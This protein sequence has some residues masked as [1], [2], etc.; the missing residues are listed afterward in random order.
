MRQARMLSRALAV[1]AAAIWGMAASGGLA[2]PV[3]LTIVHFN[4]L[5]RMEEKGG[6]GGIARLAA[7]IAGR[8]QARREPS[9]HLCRR[10]DLAIAAVGFRQGRAHDRPAEQ[11]RSL[12]D[13]ARQPRIRFGPEVARRRIAEAAFPVLGANNRDADGEIID[14]RAGIDHRRRRSVHGRHLRTDHDPDG[15]SIQAPEASSFAPSSRSPRNRRG[16][17]AMPVPISS[18]P[19]LIPTPG[20]TPN[21]SRKAPSM[22]C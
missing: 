20:R 18:L 9:G 12:R 14:G 6:R 8:T 11:A 7:V 19:S 17:C 5:D 15:R 16:R 22:S 21:Y 13:G 3:K 2:E 4:D 1:L 10:C